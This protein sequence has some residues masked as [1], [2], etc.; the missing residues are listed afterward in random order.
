MRLNRRDF[1]R[2]GLALPPTLAGL[3]AGLSLASCGDD[4]STSA[5][6]SELSSCSD[7]GDCVAGGDFNV[8]IAL[9]HGH[10]LTL[11]Q[12][13]VDAGAEIA[14]DVADNGD[15]NHTVTLTAAM[16]ADVAGGMRLHVQSA[17]AADGHSHCITINC[18]I[19]S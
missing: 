3:W 2:R 8:A 4:G 19:D 12:A 6:E 11:T 16:L 5:N 7:T 13:E 1:L 9:N 15:H 10:T 14:V 18:S 17:A